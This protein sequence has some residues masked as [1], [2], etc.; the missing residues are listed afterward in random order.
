MDW[1]LEMAFHWPHNRFLLGWEAMSKDYEYD[2]ST[3]KLYL[4]IV[5]FTLNFN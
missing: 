5:T 2:Y 4:F 3:F 1:D